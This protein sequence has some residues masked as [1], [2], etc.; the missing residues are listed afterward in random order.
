VALARDRGCLT[1]EYSESCDIRSASRALDSL[2]G[3]E[4][5]RAAV[6]L[7][8]ENGPGRLL[9]Q[10]VLVQM[11][12]P[13]AT[14]LAYDIYRTDPERAVWAAHLIMNIGHPDAAGYITAFH[15]DENSSIALTGMDVLDHLLTRWKGAWIEPEVI[16]QVLAQASE[17]PLR[18]VRLRAEASR[19][20]VRD[21]LDESEG[22]RHYLALVTRAN[23]EEE[24]G[25]HM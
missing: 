6:E 24:H 9:A 17:H 19:V 10:Y 3:D 14:T 23:D 22:R 20:L 12:S 21:D 16:E 11:M 13:T 25:E 15:A 7:I 18:A 2:V 5:I 1:D 4:T 8:V